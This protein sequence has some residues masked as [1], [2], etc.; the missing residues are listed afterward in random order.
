MK[1][2]KF[3]LLFLSF[4]FVLNAQN[5]ERIFESIAD[6]RVLFIGAGD[7]ITLCATHFV[8]RKPKTVAIAKDTPGFI[9]NRMLA[10]LVDEA[11]E[12]YD[13]GIADFEDI[14]LGDD[15]LD[16]DLDDAMAWLDD[17]END[18]DPA[19][20]LEEVAAVAAIAELMK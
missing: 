8:A 12:L 3:I 1:R 10:A 5:S 7:M 4:S 19:I 20:E 18:D 14:D 16:D 17:L 2:I 15:D 9:V 11:Y 6:Q 13:E